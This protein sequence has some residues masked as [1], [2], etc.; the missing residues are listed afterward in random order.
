MAKKKAAKKGKATASKSA[1]TGMC[2]CGSGMKA[3]DCCGC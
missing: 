3:A 2:S 1:K